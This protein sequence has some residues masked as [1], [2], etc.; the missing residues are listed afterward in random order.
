MKLNDF[1]ACLRIV[2]AVLMLATFG[3]GAVSQEQPMS[4]IRIN[5]AGMKSD[6]GQVA[7]KNL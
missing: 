1:A 6:K 5:I 2:V 4:A 3:A 7:H